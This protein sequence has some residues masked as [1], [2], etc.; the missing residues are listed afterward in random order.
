M[1]CEKV[2][3]Y[4]PSD[5]EVYM[6]QRQLQYFRERLLMELEDLN[7]VTAHHRAGVQSIH[8]GTSDP[9]DLSLVETKVAMQLNKLNHYHKKLKQ[10]ML[11]L[12]RIDKGNFG[13][14]LLT[15]NRIGLNRLKVLP[16]AT[17]AVET[18]EM[19]ERSQHPTPCPDYRFNLSSQFNGL[20][21][22]E[23][24]IKNF[25]YEKNKTILSGDIGTT[26]V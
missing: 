17:L 12:E 2:E 18:Q 3:H 25:S 22:A 16:W 21:A 5:K 14:C 19:L 11:A 24:C 26:C 20:S 15:G 8:S 1:L 23:I 10:V 6:N 7:M 9:G 4:T 13:Y